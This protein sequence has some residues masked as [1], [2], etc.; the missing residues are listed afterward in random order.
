V[1]EYTAS[2]VLPC[3]NER[4]IIGTCVKEALTAF[5]AAGISCEVVVADNGSTDGSAQEAEAAGARVI[6]VPRRGYGSAVSAAIDAS[7]GQVILTSDADGTYPLSDGPTFVRAALKSDAIVL[8][9]RFEGEIAQRA[10]PFMHRVIGSPATRLLLRMLFG[11]RCSDPHSGMRAMRREV[12]ERVRPQSVGWEFTVEMLVNAT[13]QSVPVHEI[14]IAFG[15]RTGESKLRALPEGWAFFRFLI[16]HSPTYL[17]VLPGL[18]ATVAGIAGLAWLGPADR[19][20]L[21]INSL[22]VA[23]LLTTAGYQLV[24]L[25]VCARVYVS[26]AQPGD[27]GSWARPLLRRFTLERGIVSGLAVSAAGV[28]LVAS[29]G[30]RWIASGYGVVSR[31]EHGLALTGLAVALIGLETIFSSFFLALIVSIIDRTNAADR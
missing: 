25:G 26:D 14:P 6:S 11:V 8:G 1:S 16:L 22:V 18:I 29:I 7:S 23:V 24:A 28:A 31:G 3:L 13:R 21:G 12:F 20:V 2:I 15:E 10:M 17:F 30:L 4:G 27:D 19:G 9:S 5:D